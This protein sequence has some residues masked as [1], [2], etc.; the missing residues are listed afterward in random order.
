MRY[1]FV[2]LFTLSIYASD[3][4]DLGLPSSLGQVIE[5]PGYAFCYSEKYEQPL[6]VSYKLTQTEALSKVAKRKNNF[7]ADKAITTGSA[8]LSD[9]RR[10]GFDRGHL[11]PA[12]DMAW[13]KEAMSDSFFMTNMSPQ[14]PGFN[15]GIWKVLESLV[16]RWSTIEQELYI[17]TGPIIT[18]GF[19]TIGK[20]EV[21]IPQSYYKIA[22]DLKGPQVKAIAFILPNQA[23]KQPL[24]D[25]VASIDQVEELTG[26]DFLTNL[27]A[28]LEQSLEKEQDLSLWNFKAKLNRIQF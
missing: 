7:K 17:I 14:L 19:Q 24:S 28:E 15:R 23:S 11:A 9:Y 12:A 3:N 18:P 26:L 25:Y 27:S 20:G 4:L 6:W 13:S 10:S 21:A 1:L 5:R 22:V 16:R 8:A 2:L